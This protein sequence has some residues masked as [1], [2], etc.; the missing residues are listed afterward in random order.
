MADDEKM[1]R[2]KIIEFAIAVLY[3][4]IKLLQCNNL[5]RS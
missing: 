4:K 3:V 1:E 2:V 5:E